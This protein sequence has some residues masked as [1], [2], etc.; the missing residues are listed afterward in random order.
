LEARLVAL[1]SPH[2]RLIFLSAFRKLHGERQDLI[3]Q[4]D[5]AMEAMSHRD[6]AIAVASEQFAAK[7]LEIRQK[8]A[9]LDAQ[10]RFLE[11]EGVN[12]KEVDARIA[13]Y[14]REIVS[15]L[16]SGHQTMPWS[17]DCTGR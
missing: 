14:D 7:K 17:S 15:R 12:N 13:L 9:E 3:R 2:P 6:E 4:W 8:K 5:E 11:D 16:R 1:V 10:A